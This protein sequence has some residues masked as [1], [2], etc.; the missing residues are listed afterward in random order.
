MKRSAAILGVT[1]LAVLAQGVAG[2]A[3]N[4]ECVAGLPNSPIK[5]EVFSDFQCPSCRTF[6]LE[7][8]R[9]VIDN[10]ARFNKVSVYYYDFPLAQH[11]Y[12]RQAARFAIAARQLGRAQ[13]TADGKVEAAV[14][15]SLSPEDFARVKKLS[16][17]P[18]VSEEIE[19]TVMIGNSRGV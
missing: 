7:T 12:A 8:I 11:P 10:Y 5:I 9:P 14:A 17:S 15:R 18:G 19:R 4:P 2:Y 16:E 13:W 6:Y 3:D 1:I